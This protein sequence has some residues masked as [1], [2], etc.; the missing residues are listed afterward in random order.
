[1]T[2]VRNQVVVT[3]GAGFIGSA[4]VEHLVRAGERVVVVDNLA[5]GKRANLDRLPADRLRL[6]VADIRAPERYR[7][8]LAAAHTIFHLACLGL[9]HSLHAPRENHEVNA[10]GTL[11]MLEAARSAGVP[12]FVHVSSSEVY[13]PAIT[14][15]MDE[16]HPTRPSTVYGAGKL[17]GEAYARAFHS[18]HGLPVVIVRPFNGYG[19]RC[20]H[21]GDAGEV[22]PKFVLRALAGRPLVVFG[23]G[24]QTRDFTYVDD[25]AH[26][27]ATAARCDAALGA[28]VNLG[29]GVAL[30]IL[31]LAD[32][33]AKAVGRDLH[34][35]HDTPR[36][37]DLAALCAD[38]GLAHRLFGFRPAIAFEEGLA[39][40]LAWYRGLAIPPE[41]LLDQEI[42]RN[43][44]PTCTSGEGEPLSIARSRHV[45]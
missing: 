27:I 29:S 22:I 32:A 19:P 21:E 26:G 41:R 5:N 30:R 24:E 18:S 33:V 43:W 7:D 39:R 23:S 28:T 25:I 31:D 16:S 14:S 9:R 44:L 6:V 15:P 35:A 12:R 2:A 37:G 20:H 34:I 10:T 40:L 17:A 42:E 38:A 8:E 1:M 11:A 13:G 3:G 4:L 36:P 45:G